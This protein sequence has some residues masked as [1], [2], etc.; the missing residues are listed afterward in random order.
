MSGYLCMV[1][2][3]IVH[4]AHVLLGLPEGIDQMILAQG[5]AMPQFYLPWRRS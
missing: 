5:P 4:V 2:A 1:I 3:G